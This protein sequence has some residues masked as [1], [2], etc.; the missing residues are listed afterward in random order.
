[1]ST[2]HVMLPLRFPNSGII[3]KRRQRG[4]GVAN[5]GQLPCRAGHPRSGRDQGCRGR[6][7]AASANPQGRPG[8]RVGAAARKGGACG[9]DRLRLARS[10]GAGYRCPASQ[11]RE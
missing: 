1:M 8:P 5:H 10:G 9:H 2:A 7:T 11:S 4:E 6:P 3:A